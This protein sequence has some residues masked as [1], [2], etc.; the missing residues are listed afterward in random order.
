MGGHRWVLRATLGGI[1]FALVLI[2]WAV[3][4]RRLA[5]AANTSRD[6]F[7]TILVLGTPADADGNPTPEQLARVTEGVRE[8]ERGVAPRLL[9]TG[10]PAHNH[11]VEADVMARSAAAQGIPPSAIF[12]ETKATDTIENACYSAR[13]MQA[14]GWRSAEIVSSNSHLARAAMIFSHTP[15]EWRMHAATSLQPGASESNSIMEVVK[16]M[17]YLLYA[18]WADRCEP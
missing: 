17:R 5:P 7:D 6:H 8:Y 18:S 15:L 1:A 9:F 13:I 4:A 10:G 12:V 2:C 14:H 3:M 11:Y 16:T